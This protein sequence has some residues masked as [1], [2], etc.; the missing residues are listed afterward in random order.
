MFHPFDLDWVAYPRQRRDPFFSLMNSMDDDIR[1]HFQQATQESGQDL[2][3]STGPVQEYTHSYS[4]I[5]SG[6][7]FASKK[8]V[9][10]KDADG[11]E[12][13]VEER[14]LDGKKM[15]S[16]TSNA[17]QAQ[18]TSDDQNQP[19]QQTQQQE[20][21]TMMQTEPAGVNQSDF[22][23]LWESDEFVRSWLNPPRVGEQKQQIE[24]QQHNIYQRHQDHLAELGF[25]PSATSQYLLQHYRGNVERVA[26]VMLLLQKMKEKGCTDE[27]QCVKAL[28]R[29]GCNLDKACQELQQQQQSTSLPQSTSQQP[30]KAGLQ[31]GASSQLKVLRS[32]A[33]K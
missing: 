17:S 15:T 6:P 23:R 5:Q 24:S 18:L 29:H 3:G 13:I 16:R 21:G 19:Q 2:S 9:H 26:Y 32:E 4:S 10:M 25:Q 28:L 30:A 1:R 11:R 27:Q 7:R 8:T 31:S 12:E 33:N 14:C 20:Q 22:D